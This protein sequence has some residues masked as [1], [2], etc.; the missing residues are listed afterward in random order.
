M[1]VINSLQ[2]N[3]P[4]LT[5][6]LQCHSHPMR[7]F[8][9]IL[10]NLYM[11][12]WGYERLQMKLGLQMKRVWWRVWRYH[13]S[14]PNIIFEGS[15]HKNFPEK[16]TVTLLV[17]LVKWGGFDDILTSFYSSRV[18]VQ[19]YMKQCFYQGGPWWFGQST[20]KNI[21]DVLLMRSGSESLDFFQHRTQRGTDWNT[22]RL[23][24]NRNLSESQDNLCST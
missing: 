10:L 21:L 9:S 23:S 17:K 3:I 15:P 19:I 13:V 14:Q 22:G 4:M 24:Q 6:Y 5:R 11:I 7:M 1:V 16:Y 2:V 20:N 12:T 8:F 18:W